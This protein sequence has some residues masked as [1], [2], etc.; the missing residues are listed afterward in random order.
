MPVP[1]DAARRR[2]AP[3]PPRRA[4]THD[5]GATRRAR[6]DQVAPALSRPGRTVRGGRRRAPEAARPP[7]SL[8][9]PRACSNPPTAIVS[10]RAWATGS[11]PAHR[12]PPSRPPAR[13][14]CTAGR[15]G[16]KSEAAFPTATASGARPTRAAPAPPPGFKTWAACARSPADA[17]SPVAT[18]HGDSGPLPDPLRMGEGNDGGAC[19][20]FAGDEIWSCWSPRRQRGQPRGH[21][22]GQNHAPGAAGGRAPAGRDGAHAHPPQASIWRGS[23]TASGP[24]R[25]RSCRTTRA[26]RRPRPSA[27]RRAARWAFRAWEAPAAAVVGCACRRV[28]LPVSTRMAAA[29]AARSTVTIRAATRV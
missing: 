29:S 3:G 17:P 2:R 27:Y 7:L 26:R 1:V 28:A 5:R 16:P 9:S 15:A 19:V 20:T 4:R 13:T 8:P 10:G 25:R 12:S 21:K 6:A 11:L 24:R 18:P 14:C 22:A 23:A